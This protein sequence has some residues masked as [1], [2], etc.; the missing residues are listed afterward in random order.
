VVQVGVLHDIGKTQ[1]PPEMMDERMLGSADKEVFK[2]HVVLA[3]KLL[4]GLP[5]LFKNILM[6]IMQHHEYRDGSGYPLG[7]TADKI[8]EY[9]RIV[10]VA[11]RLSEIAG[12]SVRLNPFIFTE[13]MNREMFTKLDPIICDTF[14]RHFSDYL[15]NYPLRLSDGRIADVVLIPNIN[16]SMPVLKTDDGQFIDLSKNKEFMIDS[17]LF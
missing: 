15:L 17:L 5:D 2:Q 4:H 9:A 10:A 16:P 1:L 8:H 14:I 6:G 3:L 7:L 13:S 11:I 12:D